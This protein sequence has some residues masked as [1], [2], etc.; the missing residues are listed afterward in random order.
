[1]NKNILITQMEIKL[2]II[3]F[4]KLEIFKEVCLNCK[5]LHF[6]FDS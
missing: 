5:M 6:T 4:M 3:N 2:L 1:M